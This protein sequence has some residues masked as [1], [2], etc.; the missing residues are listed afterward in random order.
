MPVPAGHDAHPNETFA[1]AP[2]G[3]TVRYATALSLVILLAMVGLGAW[4]LTRPARAADRLGAVAPLAAAAMIA[5][6]GWLSRIREYR[7]VG[8]ALVVDRPI[9]SVR[10][11]LDDLATAEHDHEALS[12]AVRLIGNGGLGA[13][14]GRFRSRRLGGFKAYVTDKYKSVVLRARGGRVWVVSPA[15]PGLFVEAVRRRAARREA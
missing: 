3:A 7:L 15:H 2:P 9:L 13:I 14:S 10:I 1:P 6:A 12:G 4:L 11:P 8:A 5:G